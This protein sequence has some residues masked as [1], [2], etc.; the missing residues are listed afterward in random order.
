MAP[1][2]RR[3]A[4]NGKYTA[5]SLIPDRGPTLPGQINNSPF[6]IN[7][8]VLQI[9]FISIVVVFLK[10]KIDYQSLVEGGPGTIQHVNHR[11]L[12]ESIHGPS[13]IGHSCTISSLR[14][15]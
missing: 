15:N 9:C 7:H 2:A 12:Y 5:Y 1:A 10:S 13:L 3:M 8:S 11:Y 6:I 4:E 14:C